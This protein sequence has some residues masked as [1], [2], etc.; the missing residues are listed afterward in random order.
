MKDYCYTFNIDGVC[1]DINATSKADAVKRFNDNAAALDQ[2][3][4]APSVFQ[5][6]Q[7]NI[8]RKVTIKDIVEEMEIP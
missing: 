5:R 1:I 2:P 3:L 8:N 7:L 6:V 4:P